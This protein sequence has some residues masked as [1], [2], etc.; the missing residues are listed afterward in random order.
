MSN[1]P[2]F[3][4]ALAIMLAGL[5]FI[6]V[7][8]RRRPLF[9]TVAVLLTAAALPLGYLAFVDLLSKPKPLAFEFNRAEK[10]EV[11]SAVLDEGKAI[12]LW[13]KTPD[14][15][16]YYEIPWDQDVALQ[17]QGAMREAQKKG[18]GIGMRLQ[19]AE[20]VP[21]GKSVEQRDPQRFFPLPFPPPPEKQ[22]VIVRSPKW[23]M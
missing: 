16:R 21:L 10:A 20:K 7:W 13:L 4:A 5:A 14:Q 9:K 19:E 1:I 2:Y 12:Y 8:S 22:R 15:P 23:Q 17:L 3:F 6:A 18:T 11:I